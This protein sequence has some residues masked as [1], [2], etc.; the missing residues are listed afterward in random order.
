MFYAESVQT[1]NTEYILLC[2]KNETEY[3]H[4]QSMYVIS[5]IY[6]NYNPNIYSR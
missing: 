2:R 6:V 1:L 5:L 4:I 3:S